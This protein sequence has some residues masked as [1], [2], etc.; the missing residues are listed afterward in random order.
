MSGVRQFVFGAAVAAALVSTFAL[1]RSGSGNDGLAPPAQAA[2]VTPTQQLEPYLRF[3]GTGTV[4]VKPDTAS[5]SF[6]TSGES[7]TKATAVNEAS[8]AMRRVIAAMVR[9]GVS[10]DDLQ[11]SADVYRDSS[12][13]V[14][15]AYQSL[16]VTVRHV[17]GAGKLLAAG[18]KAGADSSS[19]PYFSLTD[20]NR[21]Y[22]A[23]LRSAMTNARAHADTAAA[24]IGAHVTGVVSIDD[25][26]DQSVQ[27]FYG[28]VRALAIDSIA[29]IPVERGSQS[30]TASV[31][32]V[33]S[34]ATG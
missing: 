6:S 12:R 26:S 33:F 27:P 24:L 21:G 2:A 7:S 32:V 14:Y 18:L 16:Q 19:G 28:G 13:D 4:Q 9:H 25:T 23:A 8:A 34:Y 30:V 1:A 3:T 31:T 29:P 10:H 15:N 17:K 22:D 5:I 11:T 20:Q